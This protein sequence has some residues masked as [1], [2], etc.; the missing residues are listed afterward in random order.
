MD[1]DPSVDRLAE[2]SQ[3]GYKRTT[4]RA[5]ILDILETAGG[6][7]TAEEVAREVESRH[8]SLNRSTVYRTLETLAEIGVLKATR[9]GRA[10]H[11]EVSDS[12]DD[13][14]HLRC[15]ECQAMV[16]LDAGEVDDLIRR[17]AG[18]SGFLV[19]DI[20]VLVNGLCPVC[21]RAKGASAKA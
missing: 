4:Q 1:P 7:M 14:H 18:K 6:H 21:K 8:L 2:L 20:Q 13:H 3:H 10:I 15:V 9:M 12:G 19:T 11:Y 5:V 16:H 17:D